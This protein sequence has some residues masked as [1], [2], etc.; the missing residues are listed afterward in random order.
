M[1]KKIIAI[2]II[3]SGLISSSARPANAQTISYACIGRALA[4][5]MNQVIQSAGTLDHIELL[6]PAFNM[7]NP[8]GAAIAR[9]MVNAGANFGALAGVAGNA[10][11]C[12]AYPAAP[13]GW[14]SQHVEAFK[15]ASGLDMPVLI[16]E[17]GIFDGDIDDLRR[18]MDVVQSDPGNYIGALLF[19]AFGTGGGEWDRFVFD[20]NEVIK[21]QICGGSI[22]NPENPSCNNLGVNFATYYPVAETFY[23]RA[24][25][26]QGDAGTFFTLAISHIDDATIIGVNYALDRGLTPV[27]RVGTAV[28]AGPDAISYGQFLASLDNEIDNMSFPQKTVYAIA[29]PN[30][31]QTEC[32]A[33]PECGCDIS[34]NLNVKRPLSSGF[35]LGK[36]ACGIASV[37]EPEFHPLR[38]YPASPCDLLIPQS[39]PEAPYNTLEAYERGDFD[40]KADYQKYN[41]FACG[42]S[43]DFSYDEVFNPYGFPEPGYGFSFDSMPEPESYYHSY[44]DFSEVTEEERQTT[45]YYDLTCYRTIGFEVYAD[46]ANSNVGILGNTQNL[47]LTD[48]QK[49]NNYLSWYFTGTPQIGDRK[50]LDPEEPEDMDR[51]VNYSGPL[52]K[53]LPF[54]IQEAIREVLRLAVINEKNDIHN[55]ALDE[56]GVLRLANISESI[57]QYFPNI[58]N[59][60]VE[61]VA[62]EAFFTSEGGFEYPE[63]SVPPPDPSIG[64]PL[65]VDVTTAPYQFLVTCA[66]GAHE[67]CPPSR[68]G[69]IPEGT[70][71]ENDRLGGGTSSGDDSMEQ[72]PS[73]LGY[74]AINGTICYEYLDHLYSCPPGEFCCSRRPM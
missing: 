45:G 46:F 73:S 1:F 37:A 67:T 13:D 35:Y 12:C 53:L 74:C 60:T 59:S 63:V 64:W 19:N 26:L 27:I 30:E 14:I 9:E 38:P 17:T 55:Y 41:T 23:D 71:T 57:E 21:T 15:A 62:G 68:I 5:Y 11:N 40:E 7:T 66:L 2:L 4:Q 36:Y 34:S 43:L 70:G 28:E 69:I 42:S 16:T 54:E 33:A 6:S 61:D 29:G 31:P 18:E 24:D 65:G 39:N 10:Y 50:L 32:W 48:E 22:S 8:N 72:C 49:V 20:D 52:R 58:P 56:K 44:C 25:D 51:L 3:T 47:N